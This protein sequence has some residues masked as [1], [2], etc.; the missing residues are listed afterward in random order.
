MDILVKNNFLYTNEEKF[1]CAL[2]INGLT[3]NKTEGDLCTPIGK[4]KFEK[5]YYRSDKLGPLKFL[6]PS[7]EILKDDGWCDD[8][9]STFYNQHIKLP[10]MKSAERLYRDDDLYDIVCVLNYNTKPVEAGKGSAIFLH[11]S[12]PNFEGTEGC[13]AI[14]H[15]NVLELS[16]KIQINSTI[17]IEA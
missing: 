9:E 5:I 1:K 16:Q 2:G 7:K 15:K 11:A 14:E 3:M 10:S 13:I 17:I 8:P 12:K 4:F 6:I